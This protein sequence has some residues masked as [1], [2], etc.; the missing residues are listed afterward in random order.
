MYKKCACFSSSKLHSNGYY[1]N[2]YRLNSSKVLKLV[3]V[4][5][6]SVPVCKN[7]EDS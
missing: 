1:L 4:L 3:F 6:E 7:W 2:S 5:L